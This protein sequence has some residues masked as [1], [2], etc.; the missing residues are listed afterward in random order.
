MSNIQIQ[1]VYKETKNFNILQ[2]KRQS[3]DTNSKIF[4]LSDKD[5]K[6]ATI[7]MLQEIKANTLEMNG[8]IESIN[9]EI[10]H[11]LKRNNLN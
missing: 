3:T 2:G 4:E 1:T 6:A 9:K 5:V 11:F 10:E 7:I 8:K